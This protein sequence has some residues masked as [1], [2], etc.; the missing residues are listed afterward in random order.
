MNTQIER[1][2]QMPEIANPIR[3]FPLKT[4][5]FFV[6]DGWQTYPLCEWKTRI[7][8]GLPSSVNLPKK[9][10]ASTV[11]WTETIPETFYLVWNEFEQQTLRQINDDYC[12][13]FRLNGAILEPMEQNDAFGPRQLAFDL[14]ASAWLGRNELVITGESAAQ[15]PLSVLDHLSIVGHYA[16][17]H[18]EGIDIICPV[19]TSIT[20]GSWTEQGFPY[21]SGVGIYRQRVM[22][23]DSFIGHAMSIQF[24]N[25]AGQVEIVVNHKEAGLLRE[26]PW[27][28]DLTEFIIPGENLFEFRVDNRIRMDVSLPQ[29][30][31]GLLQPV[32]LEVY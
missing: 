8:P 12:L 31:S 19:P 9:Q 1:E 3:L 10:I 22:I 28:A 25:T 4:E 17:R 30:P 18:L 24:E 26:S 11:F 13:E 2:E 15:S 16:I 21:F 29:K 32:S 7:E 20:T 23:P 6:M 27:K 5:Y 14:T